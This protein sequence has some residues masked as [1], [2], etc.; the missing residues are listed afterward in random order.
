LF[1]ENKVVRMEVTPALF[2]ASG[3]RASGV[4]DKTFKDG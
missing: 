2:L 3:K 1:I 4:H